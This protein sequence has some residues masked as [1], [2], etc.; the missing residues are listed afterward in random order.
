MNGH[1][2]CNLPSYGPDTHPYTHAHT[3]TYESVHTCKQSSKW[4]KMLAIGESGKGYTDVLYTIF[5]F[6]TFL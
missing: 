1:D 6:A 5:I 2:A 4:G 3:L